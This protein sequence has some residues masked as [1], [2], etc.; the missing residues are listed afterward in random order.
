MRCKDD[1]LP[2]LTSGGDN[3]YIGEGI[4][5]YSGKAQTGFSFYIQVVRLTDVQTCYLPLTL[6]SLLLSPLSLDLLGLSLLLL[7]SL[8][9][10]LLLH[11]LLLLLFLPLSGLLAV[12]AGEQHPGYFNRNRFRLT[13]LVLLKQIK[14]NFL[15]LSFKESF[16]Q[17][18]SLMDVKSNLM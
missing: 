10:S 14:L 11:L 17:R 6:L 5:R 12:S 4:G 3:S 7:L 2:G 16:D 13:E 15:Q 1:T 18:S 8:L 9:L